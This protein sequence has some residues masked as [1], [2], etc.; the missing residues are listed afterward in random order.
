MIP[1]VHIYPLSR[2]VHAPAGEW[3]G[4]LRSI[5]E[6]KDY[7]N[8]YYLPLR[9]AVVEFCSRKGASKS[10]ILQTL[11]RRAVSLGGSRAQRIAGDNEKAFE[12]FATEFYPRIKRFRRSLLGERQQRCPFESVMLVGT[13]HLIVTDLDDRERYVFLH[14]SS[15]GDNDLKAY[16]ELLSIIVEQR[17]NAGPKDLWCMNLKTGTDVKWRPGKLTRSRCAKAAGL[18]AQLLNA[19]G[20]Q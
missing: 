17:F 11:R 19:M 16:L 12:V 6:G 10:T 3:L 18:Y 14:A 9:Q 8:R 13:P 5:E 2:L 1:E 20:A 15:W 4:M 7:A